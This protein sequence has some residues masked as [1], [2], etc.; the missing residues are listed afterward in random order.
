[1]SMPGDRVHAPMPG[2]ETLAEPMRSRWSPSV[3]DDRHVLGSDEIVRILHAGQWSPSSGNQQPWAFVVAERGSPSHAAL[4]DHLSRGNS[5]WVPRAAVVIITATQ[6]AADP[7]DPEGTRVKDP[8]LSYYDL[9]QAAAH[10][11]LQARSM[12]LHAHQFGGFDKAAVASDLGVPDH[13]RVVSGIAIGR[14]GDPLAVSERDRER[15]Q[16]ERR[17]RPLQDF[18]HGVAWGSVWD[19]IER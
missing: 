4:V 9:G 11:T 1:M 6:V 5:G 8:A 19:G 14:L 12:G 18:V 15:D 16:R 17:R 2:A 7:A 10:L 3:F 13:F